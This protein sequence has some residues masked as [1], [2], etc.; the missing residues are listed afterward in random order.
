M[1]TPLGTTRPAS[2][3]QDAP[4]WDQDAPRWAQ[5]GPKIPKIAPRA[6]DEPKMP[7]NWP[8]KASTWCPGTSKMVLSPRC[9]AIFAELAQ[10][11]VFFMFPL[12]PCPF[13]AQL[14]FKMALGWPEDA[15]RWR[16]DGS[17]EARDCPK[18]APRGP[19]QTLSWPK[20]GPR[21][22]GQTPR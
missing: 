21:R 2:W 19:R 11:R 1:R 10:L 6:Q 17:R 18:M 22:H 7:Q 20:K 13:E 3:P 15:P 14:G 8:K 5:D 16:Q 4:S 12:L 9:R